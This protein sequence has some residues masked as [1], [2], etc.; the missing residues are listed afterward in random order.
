MD[1]GG[2]GSVDLFVTLSNVVTLNKSN[3]SAFHKQQAHTNTV[4]C[5]LLPGLYSDL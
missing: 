3:F 5:T 4:Y 2:G 1:L